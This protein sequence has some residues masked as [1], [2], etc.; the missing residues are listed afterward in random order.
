MIG[1]AATPRCFRNTDVSRLP[2]MWRHNKKAWMTSALFT[3][4]VQLFNQRMR[5]AR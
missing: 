2:V 3:E 1:K 5:R 4:W